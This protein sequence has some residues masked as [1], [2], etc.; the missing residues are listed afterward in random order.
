[1]TLPGEVVVSTT[2]DTKRSG[3]SAPLLFA[4]IFQALEKLESPRF[5]NHLDAV[6]PRGDQR[7]EADT[8]VAQL[9]RKA[10]SSMDLGE[11]KRH[12]AWR[13][14]ELNANKSKMGVEVPAPR[15][16]K[17]KRK[18]PPEEDKMPQGQDQDSLEVM[19]VDETPLD[20]VVRA[21]YVGQAAQERQGQAGN[22]ALAVHMS[23]R[24]KHRATGERGSANGKRGPRSR[25]SRKATRRKDVV[26]INA[27]PPKTLASLP[28]RVSAIPKSSSSSSSSTVSQQRLLRFRT[29]SKNEQQAQQEELDSMSESKKSISRAASNTNS[30]TNSNFYEVNKEF[31]PT[32]NDIDEALGSIEVDTRGITAESRARAAAS[33]M[34][35]SFGGNFRTGTGARTRSTFTPHAK[36]TMVNWFIEHWDN[37]Y[38]TVRERHMLSTET[39]LE[40]YQVVNWFTNTRKRMWVKNRSIKKEFRLGMFYKKIRTVQ[41]RQKKADKMAREQDGSTSPK[42]T[43]KRQKLS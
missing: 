19:D 11:R 12:Y 42:H 2:S 27:V 18:T 29:T 10:K 23:A 31:L 43:G 3:E 37:P 6:R 40:K 32:S 38:P 1:M 14:R 15:R 20:A 13:V 24:L 25:N 17:R 36:R 22:Q 8:T 5:M 7:E 30:V 21:V 28:K 33:T 9:E 26:V 39:G 16:S 41:M 4:S 34:G 35:G